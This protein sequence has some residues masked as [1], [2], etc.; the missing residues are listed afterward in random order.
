VI[1]VGSRKLL[2]C[3]VALLVL[4]VLTD[5]AVKTGL[6]Q[7]FDMTGFTSVNSLRP[8][9]F[10]D[11]VMVV[12]TLYGREVVW[13][14][15]ILSLFFFGGE[16]EKKAAF[17]M[18]V[19]FLLLSGVGYIVKGLDGRIRPYDAIEG[20]RLLVPP[21]SDSSFPSGHTFIVAG[22]ATVAWLYLRWRLAALL[23]IEAFFVAFSRVYVGVHYPMDIIGGVLVGAG[24][25]LI[26]CS[27]PGF[28]D[29]LYGK[30]PRALR[31]LG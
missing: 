15:L 23:T 5:L 21:E 11:S 7:S 17:T 19:L 3:G 4:F 13:S 16:R 2:Y 29:I 31:N 26:L 20:T 24:F 30:I 9:D 25:A 28:I 27:S 18:G 6:S 8:P 12:I 1:W 22:G 14:G 10:V